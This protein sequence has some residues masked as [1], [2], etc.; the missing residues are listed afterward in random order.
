MRMGKWTY[1][2]GSLVLLALAAAIILPRY[3]IHVPGLLTDFRS[4]IGAAQSIEWSPGPTEPAAA[5]AARPPNI[6]LILAD[7]LGWNDISFYGGGPAGGTVTTP[8][9]DTIAREGVH[10]SNGYAAHSTCAPS[11]AAL[12]SGRYGT[13]FG[14]EF[15]PTPDAMGGVIARLHDNNPANLYPVYRT[16][17]FQDHE[18]LRFLDK[19]MP[20]SEITLADL[21]SAHGYHAIHIGKWH[22]GH[23]NGSAPIDQ[24]FAESLNMASGMYLPPDH[25]DAVNARQDFDPIDRFLWA[26]LRHAVNWNEG[27]RFRPDGYLTDYF[28]D[29]AVA[30]IEANRHRPFFLY[31][32]HWAPHTPLQALRADYDALAHIEDHRERVY[33]AMLVALDRGVG[34]VLETLRRHGLDDNT[35][36]IF[37]SDNGGAGYL[38]LP[39][40]NQPYRGWKL[41]F[42]EGGIHVPFFMR[43]PAAIP[44]GTT[45]HQAVHHFDI[46]ATSAAAANVPLPADRTLDGVDL[47]PWIR[48][49]RT[50]DPHAALFWRSGHYQTVRAG[51]WKLQRADRPERVWLFNL[52]ADPTEQ[53][54]LAA[55]RPDVVA[56]LIGRLDVH[57]A[58]QAAPLWPA[59]AELPVFIDK[60]LADPQDPAD[61]YVY[62][63]N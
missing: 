30:A 27:P 10:F 11:R 18:P 22:L 48:G 23:T 33:A 55:V 32:A 12:L 25:P 26:N 13:R 53:Q 50:D 49:E 31:L 51:P 5:P 34:R 63:P 54:D 2:L 40:V 4:P 35:L 42:F 8:N 20:Q 16:E 29:Q 15:T 19:G 43:W 1:I 38:G 44:A 52:E 60:T 57:N 62:V 21:L 3:A 41:T 9:I 14:F 61:E 24:G 7:D 39:E 45:V 36:V 6:V 58:E 17:H 59:L 56:G 28:T 37:T 47:L 46:F